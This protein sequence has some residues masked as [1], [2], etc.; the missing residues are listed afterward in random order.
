MDGY[1]FNS[2]LKVFLNIL[3]RTFCGGVAYF[4]TKGGKSMQTWILWLMALYGITACWIQIYTWLHYPGEKKAIHYY[5]NT[6][7]SQAKIEWM[8]R[9]LSRLAKLEGRS[10]YFY[11]ID[12]GSEDDTMRIV[13]KLN[14]HGYQIQV[15][16]YYSTVNDSD[17]ELMK[18]TIDLR[19][20]C[21]SHGYR[22]T[23]M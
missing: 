23:H 10:F 12:S 21:F 8:I 11:I 1:G 9:S 14:R 15:L 16:S 5:I 20:M 2:E 3:Q 18:V 22:P 7:N 17:S 4:T 6:Y 13:E 19:E